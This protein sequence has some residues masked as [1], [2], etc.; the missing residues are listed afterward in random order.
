MV[1]SPGKRAASGL[2]L[3]SPL[4]PISESKPKQKKN[5]KCYDIFINSKI[6]CTQKPKGTMGIQNQT[7][8]WCYMEWIHCKQKSDYKLMSIH[9]LPNKNVFKLLMASYYMNWRVSF[10]ILHCLPKK[11]EWKNNLPFLMWSSYSSMGPFT[12][13]RNA[14]M[15]SLCYFKL[16]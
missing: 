7:T 8:N 12:R 10:R 5:K 6:T 14:L 1:W 9:P 3:L 16:T 4:G 2:L 11:K 15:A 13:Q